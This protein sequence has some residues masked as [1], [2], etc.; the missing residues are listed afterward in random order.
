[1]STSRKPSDKTWQGFAE[2][3]IREAAEQGAFANV[4]GAGRPI[5]GI[6]QPL[7]ENWWIQKKLKEEQLSLV[8]PILAARKRKEQI[9]AEIQTL[10]SETQV[11]NKL[12]EVN[13]VIHE[14]MQSHIAG[15]PDGV[16]PVD[17]EQVIADWRS[18][19]T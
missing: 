16:L 15:P 5:P 8:P 7:D 11:R 14:A 13:A 6:E 18:K 10:H 4:S 19:R 1:M 17:V 12:D 2:Q 3:R 9:L